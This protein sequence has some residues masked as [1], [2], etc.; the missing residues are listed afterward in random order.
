M[1]VLAIFVWSGFVRTGIGFG[2]A[3]F[4]L[5]LLLL[6]EDRPLFFLPIIACHL[7][8][9][10]SITAA[11]RLQHIDWGFIKEA[12]AW[13]TVPKIFGVIGLLSLPTAWLVNF[14]FVITALYAISWILQREIRYRSPWV[15]RCLLIIGGYVSGVSLVGAPLIA[16]VAIKRVSLKQYRNTLFVLWFVLVSMKLLALAIAGVDLQ[17]AWAGLL[18]LPA[19]I[20]HVLG[21]K[22]HDYILH[23]DSGNV[24]R[25]LGTGLFI[26]AI[27]GLFGSL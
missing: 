13:L 1:A 17:L 4:G 21:L 5:P 27:L 19:G 3:A 20:G 15:D 24:Q 9:F 22:V 12:I 23:Q 2:G 16:A 7:L 14:V 25:I 8:F 11:G 6:V 26:V 18:L 10:S